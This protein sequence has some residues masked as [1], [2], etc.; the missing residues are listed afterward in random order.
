MKLN[1]RIVAMITALSLSLGLITPSNVSA[2][3]ILNPEATKESEI[4]TEVVET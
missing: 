1:R 2:E 3:E 4:I